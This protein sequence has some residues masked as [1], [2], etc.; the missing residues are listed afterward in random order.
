MRILGAVF[1]RENLTHFS[2][3][4][5]QNQYFLKYGACVFAS[6][7]FFP[8]LL[9]GKFNPFEQ[10]LLPEWIKKIEHAY[11]KENFF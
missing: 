4:Y 9:A 7:V 6:A 8:S 3:S 2:G 5:L 1:W 10:R 11:P